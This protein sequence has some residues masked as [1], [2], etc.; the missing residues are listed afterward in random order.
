MQFC[1]VA[2]P[3]KCNYHGPMILDV[4]LKKMNLPKIILT[5]LGIAF[6]GLLSFIALLF[7]IQINAEPS[8]AV[9]LKRN[10]NKIEILIDNDKAMYLTFL[11]V[12]DQNNNK[13]LWR[14][15]L[16]NRRDRIVY[17]EKKLNKN[18]SDLSEVDPMPLSSGMKVNIEIGY[19]YQD[20]VSAASASQNFSLIIP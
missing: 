10:G 12:T 2:S 19:H 1:S 8:I 14:I 9:Q 4:G 20:L 17:G 7:Y 6:A 11:S 5:L 15:N 18:I 13:T 16:E 3:Q